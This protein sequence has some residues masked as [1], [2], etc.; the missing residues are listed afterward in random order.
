MF[1]K[2]NNNKKKITGLKEKFKLEDLY[3]AEIGINYGTIKSHETIICRC[4]KDSMGHSIYTDVL[5]KNKYRLPNDIYSEIGENIVFN[6]RSFSSIFKNGDYKNKLLQAG[7]VTKE[8]LIQIYNALNNGIGYIES[9]EEKKEKEM[10]ENCSILTKHQFENEPVIHR[11]EELESLMISLALNKKIALVVGQ[12]GSGTTSLV[13]ELAYLIQQGKVPD[14]LQKKTILEVNIPRLKTAKKKIENH[15]KNI[16]D[17]AKT[18]NAILFI[19]EADDIVTPQEIKEEDQ[20]ILAMLRYAAEREKIKI[21][22]TT[23]SSRYKEYAN[24][25]DFKRQFDIIKIKTPTEEILSEIINRDINTQSQKNHIN[26]EN[27][28]EQLP[29]IITLL[30]ATTSS[31][32]TLM[33]TTDENPGLVL[34]IIDRSFAIAKAKK[35]PELTIDHLTRALDETKQIEPNKVKKA[36]TFLTELKKQNSDNPKQLRK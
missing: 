26:I 32:N 25:P 10:I 30:I 8:Q 4:K 13:E 9:R 24:S 12:K 36:T 22:V 23:N 35:N 20:N 15:I 28:K 33:P 6:P 31:S 2:K 14:F 1:G 18:T 34:S 3:V 29:E 7:Y 5:N 21:I 27:I 11:E 17:T 16:L 19:D